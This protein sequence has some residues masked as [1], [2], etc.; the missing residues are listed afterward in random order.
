M[1][2]ALAWGG[3]AP[4]GQ[5]AAIIILLYV[6]IS[7]IMGLILTALMMFV[8]AWIREKSEV[9]K[10]LRPSL[11]QLNQ[12][13]LASRRGEELPAELADNKLARV[14][15]KVPQMANTMSSG[16]HTV[17]QTVDQGSERV[18]SAVIE[19]RARTQM[20]K[21]MAKA[22]FLPGL[23]K[24]RAPVLPQTHE[25]QVTE[26]AG[27]QP[28]TTAETRREEPFLEQEIVMRR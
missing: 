8:F 1:S 15:A 6:F 23:N 3:I 25:V 22:F 13:L 18:A 11:E 12:A 24:R 27:E 4:W 26:R 14:V 28:A 20:V 21:G 2:F 19:F 9:I 16:M 17:E 7:I 5:A 10:T